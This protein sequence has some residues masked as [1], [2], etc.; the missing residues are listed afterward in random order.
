MRSM[1][2]SGSFTVPFDGIPPKTLKTAPS[3][4]AYI[5]VKTSY[6]A[7]IKIDS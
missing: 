2:V 5:N 4:A 3:L 1:G 7:I 6:K